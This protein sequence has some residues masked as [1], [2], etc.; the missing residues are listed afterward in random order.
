MGVT[1]IGRVMKLTTHLYLVPKFWMCGT[2]HMSDNRHMSVAMQRFVDLISMVTQ[3]YITT[4]HYRSQQYVTTQQ[5]C[6]ALQAGFQFVGPY[7]TVRCYAKD[8]C[9]PI[10]PYAF[11]ASCLLSIWIILLDSW[12]HGEK[13]LKFTS[14]THLI[15]WINR[16]IHIYIKTHKTEY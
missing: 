7:A 5:Y 13:W 16:Y 3:Q 11:T 6:N 1:E 15:C 2:S 9:T 14:N 4:L 10:V 12:T 8:N